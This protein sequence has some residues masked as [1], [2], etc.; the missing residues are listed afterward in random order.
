[1]L[2]HFREETC[3]THFCEETC[4]THSCEE[5][6]LTHFC[7]GRRCNAKSPG[8]LVGHTPPE[9]ASVRDFVEDS[10]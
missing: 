2:T 9:S 7:E 3:F 10:N 1:M 8:R 5:T 6:C 4:F